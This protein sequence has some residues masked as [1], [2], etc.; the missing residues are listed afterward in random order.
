MRASEALAQPPGP[1]G[2][3]TVVR[4]PVPP[5]LESGR[6][7]SFARVDLGRATA[8]GGGRTT[9]WAVSVVPINDWGEV[10][11]PTSG[12][13]RL[14]I[15]GPALKVDVPFTSPVWPERARLTG[16]AEPGSQ[17][18]V[19]GIGSITPDRRG[20]FEVETTLAP[21]PQVVRVSATDASG[22]T[23]IEEVS[24]VGGVDYRRFPWPAII[25]FGFLLVVAARGAVG[26]VRRRPST[27]PSDAGTVRDDPD[28]LGGQPAAEIEELPPGGGF[29]PHAESRR[30][31]G[32]DEPW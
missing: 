24:V 15:T 31:R 8:P 7:G 29:P 2:F 9:G 22:N 4:V 23:T 19:D 21:W 11:R 18:T 25:A 28:D 26:G 14:D 30:W 27:L 13:V 32:R 5:G 17:V 1:G 20:R 10:G 6:D 16:S 3:A 12:I